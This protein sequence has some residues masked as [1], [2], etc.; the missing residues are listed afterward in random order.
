VTTSTTYDGHVYENGEDD[1]D[2]TKLLKNNRKW[3]QD[4]QAADPDFFKKIGGKQRPQY[5]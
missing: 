4:S 2:I 1:P 5:L 3:V